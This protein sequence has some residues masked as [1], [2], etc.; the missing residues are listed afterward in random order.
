MRAFPFGQG[1]AG[2]VTE[3]P[4]CDSARGLFGNGLAG[5]R[6]AVAAEDALLTAEIG[7]GSIVQYASC[8]VPHL[9]QNLEK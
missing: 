4:S 1:L 6:G 8:R 2:F 5:M 7:D 9:Q 3:V